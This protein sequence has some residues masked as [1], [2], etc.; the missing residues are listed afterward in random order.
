MTGVQHSQN[1][2]S[3]LN[4][5]EYPV[6]NIDMQSVLCVHGHKAVCRHVAARENLTVQKKRGT[7]LVLAVSR[8]D[9]SK[10]RPSGVSTS[11]EIMLSGATTG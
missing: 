3:F 5:E 7:H 4:I 8:A 11:S 1:D 2:Y 9:R 10:L 6:K